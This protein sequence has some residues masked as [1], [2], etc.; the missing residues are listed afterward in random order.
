MVCGVSGIFTAQTGQPYTVN[1]AYDVNH[2]GNLT[3]RLQTTTGPI[4][5]LAGNDR[6]QVQAAPGINLLTL[7][8]PVA[9]MARWC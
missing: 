7:L 3:H 1:T 5:G 9:R 6:I 8:A 4:P 2:D